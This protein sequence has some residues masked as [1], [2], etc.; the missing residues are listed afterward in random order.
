MINEIQLENFKSFSA[1]QKIPLKPITLIYGANSS[2]KSSIL[3]S[4]AYFIELNRTSK[5]SIHEI[6]ISNGKIVLG[7]IENYIHRNNFSENNK[8]IN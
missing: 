2:G 4:L 1:L 7:G 8:I 6:P 5:T 3:H